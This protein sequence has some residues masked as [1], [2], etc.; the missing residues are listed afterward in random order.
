[1]SL[2][3]HTYQEFND[4]LVKYLPLLKKDNPYLLQSAR[5]EVVDED[6]LNKTLKTLA[7]R[8]GIDNKGFP[9]AHWKKA[10]YENCC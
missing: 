3:E 2:L 5:R 4:S 6:S 8:A 9:L 10:V 7:T 1:V